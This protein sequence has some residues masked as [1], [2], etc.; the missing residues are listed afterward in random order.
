M[1]FTQNIRD[2]PTNLF[3]SG[4]EQSYREFG[5]TIKELSVKYKEVK[6]IDKKITATS[7]SINEISYEVQNRSL[8]RRVG[9]GFAGSAAAVLL[10]PISWVAGIFFG[11]ASMFEG[12]NH[13]TSDVAQFLFSAPVRLC[14]NLFAKAMWSK[15]KWET[16]LENAERK[17]IKLTDKRLKA[18]ND[19]SL[20]HGQMQKQMI[21]IIEFGS[22]KIP[23]LLNQAISI[24]KKVSLIQSQV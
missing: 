11:A 14:G 1:S 10:C 3:P 2:N 18:F 16:S 13:D 23:T 21:K 20:L 7:N 8:S 6:A 15:E 24:G 12:V 19:V 4:E 5:S 9:Y 22:Y 17:K